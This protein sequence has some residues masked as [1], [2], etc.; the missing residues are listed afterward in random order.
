MPEPE[1]YIGNSKDYID[2]TG[3]EELSQNPVESD[4]TVRRGTPPASRSAISTLPSVEIKLEKQ[5]LN[6]AICRDVV[7]ICETTRKLPCGHGYYGDCII[8][9]L[10]PRNSCPMCRVELPTDDSKYEEEKKDPCSLISISCRSILHWFF[11]EHVLQCKCSS[12]WRYRIR[13]L[14]LPTR[15]L[16]S[17]VDDVITKIWTFTKQDIGLHPWEIS[18]EPPYMHFPY[19]CALKKE[20][21]F[22]VEGRF[23]HIEGR[24]R[25]INENEGFFLVI[26]HGEIYYFAEGEIHSGGDFC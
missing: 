24:C 6:C 22:S 26:A 20:I 12:V 9:W 23:C 17:T 5:V 16:Q 19:T 14:Q 2:A 10:N 13:H 25:H 11:S 8:I 7:S 18:N 3:Y 15:S 21:E 1:G 4:K